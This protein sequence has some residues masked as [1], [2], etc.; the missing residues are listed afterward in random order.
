MNDIDLR[1]VSSKVIGRDSETTMD[2]GTT[3][4]PIPEQQQASPDQIYHILQNFNTRVNIR[5]LFTDQVMQGSYQIIPDD[6]TQI[7]KSWR[8]QEHANMLKMR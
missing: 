2:A 6:L 5:E 7:V 4:G 8:A 3:I 1:S